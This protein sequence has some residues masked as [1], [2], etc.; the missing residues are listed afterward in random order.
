ME[1]Q[2]EHG[3]DAERSHQV[4]HANCLRTAQPASPVVEKKVSKAERHAVVR[5]QVA[6]RPLDAIPARLEAAKNVA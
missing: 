2:C 3:N 6:E 5:R 4:P 1:Q